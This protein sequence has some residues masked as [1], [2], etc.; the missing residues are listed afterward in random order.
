MLAKLERTLRTTFT[1]QG[2]NTKSTNDGSQINNELITTDQQPYNLLLLEHTK[3][4]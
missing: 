1:K 2:P 4:V 3:N